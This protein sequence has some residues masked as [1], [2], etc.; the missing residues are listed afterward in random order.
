M[1]NPQ[2]A[3]PNFAVSGARK[4]EI[5]ICGVSELCDALDQKVTH[6]I[7]ILDPGF[8]E[9]V[10][11]A[12][13]AGTGLLRLRFHDVIEHA[14]VHEAPHDDHV[15]A[16]LRFGAD[17]GGHAAPRVLVHCHMGVSRSTAAAIILLASGGAEAEEAVAHIAA[18]RPVAW[19]NLRMIEIADAKLGLEA[20]LVSAVRRHHA[21][22]LRRKPELRDVFIRYGRSR[23]VEGLEALA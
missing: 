17:I 21:R 10:H 23:E 12:T 9:P 3:A 19:P 7:S 5:V 11:V 16:I 15:D 20:R 1:T 18:I 8:E 22:A 4:A 2:A 13:F 14:P 6:V